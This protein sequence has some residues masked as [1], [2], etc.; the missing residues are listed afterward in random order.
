VIASLKE[1]NRGP[2]EKFYRIRRPDGAIRWIKDRSFPVRDAEGKVY[3]VVG[4]A[5]DI[6]PLRDAQDRLEATQAQVVSNA[7]F[8]A[9]GEMASGIAH[10]INNPLA[11]ILG[12][13]AQLRERLTQMEEDSFVSGGLNTIDKMSKRIASIIKGLRTFS[14]Q[15]DH[16]PMVS[17]DLVSIVHETIAIC[18]AGIRASGVKLK[19]D[20]PADG[21][22]VRCRPSEISQVVLNLINN[23][24]DAVSQSRKR[25]ISLSLKREEAW[26]YLIVDDSGPGVP[27]DIRERIFQPFFT[28][29]DVGA[30]TGLGLSISKGIVEAHGGKLYL[31]SPKGA[32]FVVK[33]PTEA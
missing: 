25:S 8:A 31:D 6:T 29:K 15:T 5:E 30:G 7:K 21:L 24:K 33:L 12:L 32:R 28:T 22:F 26:A 20:I 11:V 18:D 17:A 2:Y 16:D 3:R 1:H 23:A 27:T 10:E 4:I 9:L 19:I 14:R 13:T